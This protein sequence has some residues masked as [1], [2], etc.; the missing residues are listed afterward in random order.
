FGEAVP[1]TPLGP[2]MGVTEPVPYAIEPAIGV[3]SPIAHEGVYFRQVRRGNI[4]FGGGLRNPA[5]LDERR[6]T[7][8]PHFTIGQLHELRRAMPAFSQLHVI[9]TWSGIEGYLPDEDPVMGPSSKVSG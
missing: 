3:S 7:A 4:V 2:M 5:F 9:R 6:V 1:L 8:E